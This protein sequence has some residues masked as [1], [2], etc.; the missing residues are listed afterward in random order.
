MFSRRVSPFLCVT[1]SSVCN[2]S[3]CGE[4][5]RN[6]LVSKEWLSPLNVFVSQEYRLILVCILTDFKSCF[7][8]SAVDAMQTILIHEFFPNLLLKTGSLTLSNSYDTLEESSC[9]VSVVCTLLFGIHH[10]VEPHVLKMR[11]STECLLHFCHPETVVQIL[12]SRWI[13]F[14]ILVDFFLGCNR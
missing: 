13:S 5:S 7:G 12:S 6:S 8:I 3:L 14:F 9:Q 10:G 4:T 1:H 2:T 11:V